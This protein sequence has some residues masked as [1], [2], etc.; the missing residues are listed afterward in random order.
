[1]LAKKVDFYG[2]SCRAVPFQNQ[3]HPL[4][5]LELFRGQEASDVGSLR[6]FLD[7]KVIKYSN[8]FHADI[9]WQSVAMYCNIIHAISWKKYQK[10]SRGLQRWHR[11]TYGRGTATVRNPPTRI[12]EVTLQETTVTTAMHWYTHFHSFWVNIRPTR[13][14][15]CNNDGDSDIH[16][17]RRAV[18]CSIKAATH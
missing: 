7:L 11:I 1:M 13:E 6:R 12:H 2:S 4:N 14:R 9:T 15:L 10:G 5:R 8:N 3:A 18:N 17:P 16:G